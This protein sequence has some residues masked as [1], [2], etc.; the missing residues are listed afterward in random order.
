MITFNT[1]IV[2]EFKKLIREEYEGRKDNLATGCASNFEHYQ[3]LIGIIQ[4]LA[5]ALEFI[6][7]AQ[8]NAEKN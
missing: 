6:E 5:I 2:N 1:V 7:I 3:K 8:E 4:G